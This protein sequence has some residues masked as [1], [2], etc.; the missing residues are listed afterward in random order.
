M[1]IEEC[2]REELIRVLIK[3]SSVL[4]SETNLVRFPECSEMFESVR[5]YGRVVTT[6]QF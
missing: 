3:G 2:T 5:L 6:L 1:L 4:A